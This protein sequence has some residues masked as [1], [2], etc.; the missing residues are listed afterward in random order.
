MIPHS[1]ASCQTDSRVQV[2]WQ[3]QLIAAIRDPKELCRLLNLAPADV[4]LS[5]QA[6]RDF[7]LLVPRA[8]VGL[9]QP[10]NP[11]DP[12]LLQ[13]LNRKEEEVN[14][15]GFSEDPLREED[16]TPL[17]GLVHKYPGRVLLIVSGKCAINCRYCFRRSFD[18]GENNPGRQGWLD[19]M[20]YI[21]KQ[22]GITEVI[23][24][25]GDPLS[26]PD[27]H[28]SWLTQQLETIPHLK[29]L[30]IHTRLPV[31]IPDRINE[32]F[33]SWVCETRLR[34]QVVL[35]INHP[36]EIGD[37]LRAA[38]R[39]MRA[40]GLQPLNQSVLL[41]GINDQVDTL[42]ALQENGYD[43]G[44]LPYYLFCLDRVSGASH[45]E[46][47]LQEAKSLWN[48]LRTGLPGYLVPRLALEEAGEKSKT[49]IL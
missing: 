1:Q 33:L 7:P 17:P 14:P 3:S 12:L 40:R 25:G 37:G 43:A 29:R 41:K 36:N 21:R 35:H 4:D 11:D 32:E 23:F 30:R 24:S 5:D 31:V 46:V 13:V 22:P 8:F 10:G 15:I 19:V 47:S 6:C 34:V 26:A 2:P 20:E 28:L 44:I 9:M 39:K 45:F 27:K 38:V 48:E 42:K 16:F 18:Y 49:L